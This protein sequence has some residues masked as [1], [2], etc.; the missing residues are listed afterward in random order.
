MKRPFSYLIILTICFIYISSAASSNVSY[1]K[2][3]FP[4]SCGAASSMAILFEKGLIQDE[5]NKKME[6]KIYEEIGI[7]YKQTLDLASKSCKGPLSNAFGLVSMLP[8][9]PLLKAT[10]KNTVVGNFRYSMPNSINEFLKKKG[11]EASIILNEELY[12]ELKNDLSDQDFPLAVAKLAESSLKDAT[13]IENSSQSKESLIEDI[14]K[15]TKLLLV[16][17]L[18]EVKSFHYILLRK[19]KHFDKDR[20]LLLD[21]SKGR[22]SAFNDKQVKEILDGDQFDLNYLNAKFTGIA[23]R[24]D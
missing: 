18:P 22:N 21:P 1:K 9:E 23:L 20:F 3:S 15:G 14:N 17:Y 24:I 11:I 5:K 16:L 2:Q 6:S 13:I 8:F 12:Q 4:A 10:L 19:F 7:S